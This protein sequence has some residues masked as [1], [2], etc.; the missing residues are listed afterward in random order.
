MPI[1]GAYA[2]H[3][4]AGHSNVDM[5]AADAE[6]LDVEP[7]SFDAAVC[8]LGLMLCPDPLRALRAMHRAIKP[9][10]PGLHDG[11][12]DALRQSMRGDAHR[13]GI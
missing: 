10:G 7:E 3:V 1:R 6:A 2:G 12:L 9:G 13:D 4:R 8:R 11:V 5:L